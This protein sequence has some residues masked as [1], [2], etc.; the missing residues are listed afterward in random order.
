MVVQSQF[1]QI[2]DETTWVL[3]GF[4][5]LGRD[6]WCEA[7]LDTL[8]P[9]SARLDTLDTK[10]TRNCFGRGVLQPDHCFHFVSFD[11]LNHPNLD[12]TSKLVVGWIGVSNS[13]GR[14]SPVDRS[15]VYIR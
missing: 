1:G 3:P 13:E 2:H 8:I 14:F 5:E 6:T 9:F 10:V 11:H 12:V 15:Q 7:A 4:V